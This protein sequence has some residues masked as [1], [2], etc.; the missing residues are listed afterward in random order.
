VVGNSHDWGTLGAV[1][2]SPGCE[3]LETIHAGHVEIGQNQVESAALNHAE[4]FAAIAGFEDVPA[5]EIRSIE[6]VPNYF[7]DGGGI[8]DK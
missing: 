3:E 2:I 7:V 1:D 8:V 5:V 6:G 4:G